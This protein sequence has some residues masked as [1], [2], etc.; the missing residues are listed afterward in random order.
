MRDDQRGRP[1]NFDWTNHSQEIA[2]PCAGRFRGNLIVNRIRLE[3]QVFQ[4]FQVRHPADV[5]L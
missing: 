2:P 5:G 3:L 4:A 1:F